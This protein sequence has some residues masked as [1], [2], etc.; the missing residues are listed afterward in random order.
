MELGDPRRSALQ[1][2][3]VTA[4]CRACGRHLRVADSIVAGFGPTC[5]KALRGAVPSGTGQ[6]AL[7]VTAPPSRSPRRRSRIHWPARYRGRRVRTLPDIA[8]YQTKDL[9]LMAD[10]AE[11]DDLHDPYAESPDAGDTSAC[12][13]HGAWHARQQHCVDWPCPGCPRICLPEESD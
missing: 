10:T 11:P 7:D 8:T 1:G 2:Q 12:D 3:P 13:C 6:L 4:C 9:Y 5:R